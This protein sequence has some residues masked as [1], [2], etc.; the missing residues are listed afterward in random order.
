MVSLIEIRR[1]LASSQFSQKS[2]AATNSADILHDHQIEFARFY[3]GFSVSQFLPL[4]V[5]AFPSTLNNDELDW[6]GIPIP[7]V[8]FA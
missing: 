3:C 5:F 7:D 8:L 1:V 4:E 6:A 2:I